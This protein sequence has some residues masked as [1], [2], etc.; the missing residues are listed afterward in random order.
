VIAQKEA[1]RAKKR[2]TQAQKRGLFRF[3][4]VFELSNSYL[5][6]RFIRDELIIVFGSSSFGGKRPLCVRLGTT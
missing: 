4:I 2:P 1:N 6:G 3:F 5:E